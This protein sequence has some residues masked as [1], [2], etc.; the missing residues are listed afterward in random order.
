MRKLRLGERIRENN[1]QRNK[2]GIVKSAY[3]RKTEKGV[4]S[5]P[6]HSA[7]RVVFVRGGTRSLRS[8]KKG[9]RKRVYGKAVKAKKSV[10][11]RVL[12]LRLFYKTKGEGSFRNELGTR[13]SGLV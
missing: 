6:A 7:T 1:K 9:E 2:E 3:A 13:E 10:F 4:K 8:F 12:W 5:G 11:F